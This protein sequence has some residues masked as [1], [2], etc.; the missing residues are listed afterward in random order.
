MS[1]NRPITTCGLDVGYGNGKCVV[2]IGDAPPVSYVIPVGAAP[3]ERL[4]KDLNGAVDL[5]G[6]EEVFVRD[7][8]W[9][10]GV[11]PT[12]L[13]G[14]FARQTHENY[15]AEPEYLALALAMMAKAGVR[16]I[17]S[18]VAGLPCSH[19]M[20][21]TGDAMKNTIVQNL[22]KEHLVN[23]R[24]IC[25]VHQV[26][27]VPQP[28][29]AFCNLVN[30]GHCRIDESLT[31]ICDVGYGTVDWCV[32]QGMRVFD[33]NSGSSLQATS[34]ILRSAVRAIMRDF[35]GSKLSEDRLES[36]LRN[37]AT[38]IDLGGRM[39]PFRMFLESAAVPISRTVMAD[40]ASS[41]RTLKDSVSRVLLTGGGACFYE[42]A[43]RETFS[44]LKPESVMVDRDPVLANARGFQ[45]LALEVYNHTQQQRAA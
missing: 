23:S 41:L 24:S 5:S 43:A 16:H 13:Q 34:Q 31:L 40:V 35:P 2:Q 12:R 36:H 4:G 26:C 3:I 30:T 44:S 32:V 8:R 10:A 7:A 27:V 20:G 45:F 29:G 39:I 37:G 33:T 14:G 19:I 28:I 6:G 17:D 18:L 42:A 1:S 11:D 21:V 38:Y 22:T 25:E 9:V 15:V